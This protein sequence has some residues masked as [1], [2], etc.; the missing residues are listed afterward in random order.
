MLDD[1]Q[2]KPRAFRRGIGS[3]EAIERSF[4][5]FRGQS[6]SC[7]DNIDG[8]ALIRP[9]NSHNNGCASST[10]RDGVI[11]VVVDIVKSVTMVD[12]GGVS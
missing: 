9:G 7:V 8:H 10:V 3:P 4:A 11:D 6:A 1:C 2:P 12:R 5:L